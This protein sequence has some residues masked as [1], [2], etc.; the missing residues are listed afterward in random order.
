M[1][2]NASSAPIR[3]FQSKTIALTI[4]LANTGC[5]GTF[6]KCY[7]LS[8]HPPSIQEWSDQREF[9]I[10]HRPKLPRIRN[11]SRSL[12]VPLGPL[13]AHIL[14]AHRLRLTGNMPATGKASSHRTVS[15]PVPSICAFST[16]SADGRD[17]PP[18]RPSLMMHEPPISLSLRANI[19][20][21]MWVLPRVMNYSFP[22][23]G[24][25]T[26]SMNGKWQALGMSST[27]SFWLCRSSGVYFRPQNKEELFNLRH[28]SARNVV[29]RIFGILKRRFKIL[30]VAPEYKMDVQA[31]IPPALCAIHN[32]IR[33]FD[34]QDIGDYWYGEHP[35]PGD[36]FGDL[37]QGPPTRDSRTRA[38]SRRDM[39]AQT[40]W[41]DY[42]NILSERQRAE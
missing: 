21:L 19:T 16:F 39:I 37:A 14:H 42:V 28:A 38:N 13:T 3:R 18:M 11:S 8:P 29:E 15:W 41:D 7:M 33:E 20:W 36:R 26:I 9:L 25:A 35:M 5:L 2:G 30:G 34:P 23:A 1:L 10:Q 27:F 24:C 31:R 4:L 12:L 6:G 40:M 17:L 22:I 32:F